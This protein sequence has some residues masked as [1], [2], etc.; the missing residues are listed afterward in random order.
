MVRIKKNE[1]NELS[2]LIAYVLQNGTQ[3]MEFIEVVEMGRNLYLNLMELE[4]LTIIKNEL[5]EDKKVCH[6]FIIGQGGALLRSVCTSMVIKG[7]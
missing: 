4:L 2:K 5:M 7:N 6:A 1:S 3:T